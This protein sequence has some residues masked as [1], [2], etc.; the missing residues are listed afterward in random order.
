MNR[1][2]DLPTRLAN[3][4]Q[5][6]ADAVSDI[7][8]KQAELDR[9]YELLASARK[10]VSWLVLNAPKNAPGWAECSALVDEIDNA[11]TITSGDYDHQ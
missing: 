8:R 5:T 6:C 2:K 4:W 11:L 10:R 3:A 7:E 1:M 9:L